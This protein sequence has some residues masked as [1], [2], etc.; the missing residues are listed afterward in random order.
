M[1]DQELIKRISSDPKVVT[2][3]PVIRGTRLSVDF[4]LNLLAHGAT[5]DEILDEYEGLTMQDI[6]ACLLFA[7]Q[8]IASAAFMPLSAEPA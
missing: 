5:F 4:I 7:S 1:S 3:K 6:Q 2:G 8:T